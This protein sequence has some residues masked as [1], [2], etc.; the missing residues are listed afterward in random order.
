[1]ALL[2]WLDALLFYYGGARCIKNNENIICKIEK[3][4]SFAAPAAWN[5]KCSRRFS[6]LPGN[7]AQFG[8]R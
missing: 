2:F 5:L 1:M 3:D 7:I 6:F 8:I 4:D